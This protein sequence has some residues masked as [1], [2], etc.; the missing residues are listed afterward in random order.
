M[1]KL[2]PCSTLCAPCCANRYLNS[3][4]LHQKNYYILHPEEISA[5][6]AVLLNQPNPL[7]KYREVEASI[8]GLVTFSPSRPFLIITI[9]GSVQDA[10]R[11]GQKFRQYYKG[12]ISSEGGGCRS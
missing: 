12:G 9:K 7:Q 4:H 1:S 10:Q 3:D 6:P 2:L 5:R 8:S 11:L